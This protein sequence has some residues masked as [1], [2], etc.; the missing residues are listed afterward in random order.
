MNLVPLT[1]IFSITYGN[2][3]DLNKMRIVKP[4]DKN[5]IAF[6][7]R[8]RENNGVISFVE[9]ISNVTPY[10]TGLITVALGGSVLSSFIQQN[11]FYTGQNVA[12]LKP[13]EEMSF[14]VKVYYCI[15]IFKNAFRYSTCGREANKTL[16]TIMIPPLDDIPKYIHSTTVPNFYNFKQSVSTKIIDLNI[17]KWKEFEYSDIFEIKKG[18][19]VTKLDMIEGET[20]F[21][22]ATDKNNGIREYAGLV[23]M[24]HG[25][26]ITV[27]Y[28]GSVGEA[29][30]QEK[31][32]WASDDVNVLYPK[33]VLNKYIAMFL[34][35]V[36]K[37][38]KYRFNYGRKW[39]KERMDISTMKLPVK[40]DGTPDWEYMENYIKSLPYSASI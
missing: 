10:E 7:S 21:I 32:F 30:Y 11:N 34:I 37:Q 25:N 17:Q 6:V 2:K 29:F 31:P 1:Q 18:K 24:F 33:F 19:R 15:A 22:S 5:A 3:L 20:P 13:L 28:N 39:H 23:E 9:K 26:V 4:D 8:T 35:A 36:I 40:C 27:N 38:D 16:R 14:A 12:V